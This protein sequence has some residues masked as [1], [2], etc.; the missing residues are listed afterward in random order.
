MRKTLAALLSIFLLTQLS[1][2][3]IA[4]LITVPGTDPSGIR[5]PR[6]RYL[7]G[8]D[9]IGDSVFLYFFLMGGVI[10][11]ALAMKLK[12]GRMLF[13]NLELII[14]FLT[15]F[16]LLLSIYPDRPLLWLVPPLVLAVFRHFVSH[17]LLSSSLSIFLAAGVGAIM[18]VSL[19]I[20]PIIVLMAF[21]SV[22]DIIAVKLS[23]HMRRVVEHIRGTNSSFLV[24][25]PRLRA[26][27]GVSDLA[28]PAMLVTST[29]LLHSTQMGILV[30]LAGAMGLG[31]AIIYS[32][33]TG[34]VPALP[35]IFGTSSGMYALAVAL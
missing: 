20:L 14:V 34:M 4:Y 10:V 7:E 3:F 11:I 24:E 18:G 6:V 21:L 35:F 19:G 12:L 23:S 31:L 26:A 16:L 29:T 30:G 1:A 22:Y 32:S 17:W 8:G 13:R 33:K 15:A 9:S 25:I 28:V 2:I 27:V 5:E